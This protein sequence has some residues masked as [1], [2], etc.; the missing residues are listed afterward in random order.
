[1]W[2]DRWFSELDIEGKILWVYLLTN[3][4]AS[5][6]GIYLMTDKIAAFE[7]GLPLDRVTCLLS[8]FV[9]AGKIE[10]EN[11]VIWV[12]R[13]REYQAR[14]DSSSRVMT[15]ILKDIKEVPEGRV[16]QSYIQRYGIDTVSIPYGD[17]DTVTGTVTDTVTSRAKTERQ[18]AM[19]ELETYFAEITKLPL[20]PR[21]ND[22]EKRASAESW[23][24]PL[25]TLYDMVDKDLRET[26]A[27]IKAAVIKMTNDELTIA[28]PRSI[29]KVAR[30]EWAKK[31]RASISAG[32][33]AKVYT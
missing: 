23:W 6:S 33:P 9:L 2:H 15:R 31:K 14:N 4:N 32:Q 28:S 8:Q 19:I 22:K 27:L 29:E 18:L 24:N 12:R 16:K 30:S 17:T 1:M 13:M 25:G 26:K 7:T 10:W 11:D 5:V 3:G 20:P 21:G